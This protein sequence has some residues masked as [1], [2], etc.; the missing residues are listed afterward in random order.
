MTYELKNYPD[1][2]VD[3]VPAIPRRERLDLVTALVS[4]VVAIRA[5]RQLARL[6][7]SRKPRGSPP[8]PAYLRQDIGLPPD[9]P[10]RNYWDHQ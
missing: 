8:L 9:E 1:V 4:A 10:G 6:V 3:R 5:R 2:R 7:K